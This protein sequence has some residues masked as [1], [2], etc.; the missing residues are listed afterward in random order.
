MDEEKEKEKEKKRRKMRKLRKLSKLKQRFSEQLQTELQNLL[1]YWQETKAAQSVDKRREFYRMIHSLAGSASTF[2]YTR[3]GK[4][5]SNLENLLSPSGEVLFGSDMSCMID[6]ALNELALEVA[7]GPD[8]KLGSVMLPAIP[9]AAIDQPIVYILEGDIQLANKTASQLEHFGYRVKTF[10]DGQA[11]INAVQKQRP[12]VMMVDINMPES[13]ISGIEVVHKLQKPTDSAIPVLFTSV[14]DDW[15]YRLDAVRAGGEGYIRKPLNL[16]ELV[17]QLDSILNRQPESRYRIVIVD[18]NALLAQHY[19][20]VLEAADMEAKVVIDSSDILNILT[21]FSPDVILMDIH[22]PN[23]SGVEVAKVIRQHPGYTNLPIVYLS[24]ETVFAQQLEALRVGGDDFLQKPIDDMY[25]VTA[26]EIRVQRFRELNN[27]MNK[28]SL[29]GL[30]NYINLKLILE[31]E[32]AQA[33]RQ[34]K[35]LCL[36]MLS[37]DRFKT[38]SDQYGHLEGDRVIKTLAELL[39]K[40]L[41][42]MDIAAR[43]GGKEF[44]IILPDTEVQN[45][46]EVIEEIRRRFAGTSFTHASG[47]Y[48]LSFSAGIAEH[49]PEQTIVN[50]ISAADQALY[51]AKSEG[52]NCT[53]TYSNVTAEEKKRFSRKIVPMIH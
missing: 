21:S 33:N 8:T 26:V 23:I 50:L 46:R 28:D 48:Y 44:A 17:S 53:K 27:L 1:G 29:T 19:A 22:M 30:H 25:L 4:A 51:D 39:T 31:R 49:S 6:A 35:T 7:K 47:N 45:A 12:D 32:I 37:I 3:L 40:R 5:C 42:K 16:T 24:T 10:H 38:V 14:Y 52:R 15:H 13:S 18:D 34:S 43:Y 41:R 11:V 36:V 9:S 20:T 2:G